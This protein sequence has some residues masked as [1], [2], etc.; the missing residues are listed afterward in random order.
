MSTCDIILTEPEIRRRA[1]HYLDAYLAVYRARLEG[2]PLG[3]TSPLCEAVARS[4]KP[5]REALGSLPDGAVRLHHRGYTVL[6][7]DDG[8][9][10]VT[11]S[12]ITVEP[13]DA[14]RLGRAATPA[15]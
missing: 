4:A 13:I 9:L 3:Y 1:E 15:N 7:E 11:G 2:Y 6:L 12:K 8:G 14:M 10:Y 5:C